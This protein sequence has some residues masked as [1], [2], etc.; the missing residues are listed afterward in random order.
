MTPMEWNSALEV[1]H[2]RIDADHRALVEVLNQLRAAMAQGKDQADIDKVLNFLMDYTV[3][4]F[5]AEESL[6]VQHRFPGASAHFAAHAELVLKLSDLIGDY[7]SGKPMLSADI[8]VFLESW[9][10]EHILGPDMEFG[11]F[12]KN[13]GAKG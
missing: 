2:E 9:L 13:K 6:M 5:Q 11:G 12:L 7:R 8:Q 10:L 1:G 4:H 3:T